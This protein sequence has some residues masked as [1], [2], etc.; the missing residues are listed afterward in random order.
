[1]QVANCYYTTTRTRPSRTTRP[2]SWVSTTS[3]A[4]RPR[5]R[6]RGRAR[7]RSPY[8]AGELWPGYGTATSQPFPN[9]CP[10]RISTEFDVGSCFRLPGGRGCVRPPWTAARRPRAQPRRGRQRTPRSSTRS[11]TGRGTTTT[12]AIS[13]TPVTSATAAGARYS[14]PLAKSPMLPSSQTRYMVALRVRL[15][16]TFVA[17]KPNCST[18]PST[19]S[20]SGTSAASSA[21]TPSRERDDLRRSASPRFRGTGSTP[22]RSAGFG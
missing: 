5:A 1:M 20:A 18:T 7:L 14:P 16:D 10:A 9:V 17:N 13:A 12:S 22:V 6:G 11:S 19:A 2:C 15:Q 21:W 4:T 3:A 8:H